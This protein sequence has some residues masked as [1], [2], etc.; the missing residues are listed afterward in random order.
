MAKEITIIPPKPKPPVRKRVG[1][2][3]R[4][5]KATSAQIHSLAAQAS[6]LLRYV[7]TVPGWIAEDIYIDICSGATMESRPE[8][9]RMLSDVQNGKITQV[10]TKSV[11]RFGRNAEEIVVAF[12]AIK[13]AGADIYFHEQDLS[14]RRAD[15]ELYVSIFGACAQEDN[16]QHS[17]NIKWGINKRVNDG[18]SAIYN[19]PCYGYRAN[20]EKEIEIVPDEAAVVIEIYSLYIKGLS[21]VKIKQYLESMSVLSPTGKSTWSK[22]TIESILTNKKYIGNSVAYQTYREGYPYPKT[23][24]NRGQRAK[25]EVSEHY[26]PIIPMEIFEA[27]QKIRQERTN[28][29]RDEEGRAHRKTK[30]YSAAKVDGTIQLVEE[31]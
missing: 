4:V 27:V 23:I 11:S 9:M 21:V 22:H 5:S 17:E 10:V 13:E 30:K 18:S 7:M 28:I 12:R 16:R 8:F 20:E 15:C 24:V 29:V 26:V 6:F 14:S 3:C 2:Y 19:R 1:I 25:I 31:E